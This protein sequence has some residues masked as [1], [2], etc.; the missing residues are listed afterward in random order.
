MVGPQRS[1]RGRERSAYLGHASDPAMSA[2]SLDLLIDHGQSAWCAH[3]V[4]ADT[5]GTIDHDSATDLIGAPFVQ[6]DILFV[7]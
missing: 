4:A 2:F 7:A 1:G 5:R 3:G 6:Q